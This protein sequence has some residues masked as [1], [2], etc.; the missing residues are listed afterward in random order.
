L[1]TVTVFVN[2][3]VFVYTLPVCVGQ[4]VDIEVD[5]EFDIEVD[6]MVPVKQE[7]AVA[8]LGLVPFILS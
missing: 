4:E 3:S 2:I 5:I 6:V 8:G 1:V 7:L